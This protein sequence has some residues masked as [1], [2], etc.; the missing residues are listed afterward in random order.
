MHPEMVR[1]GIKTLVLDLEGLLVH[2]EWTRAKGWQVYKRPGVQDFLYNLAH[3][4]ELVIY[5]DEPSMYADPIINRL[6]PYQAVTY[7]LFRQDTQYANGKHVRDLSKL[8]R[9]PSQ[10]LFISGEAAGDVCAC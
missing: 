3:H 2:K 5:T 7:K 10:V 1:K 4:Y 9:D 6:D 8:N